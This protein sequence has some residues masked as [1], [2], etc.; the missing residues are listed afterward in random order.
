MG[1]R[2]TTLVL[3]AADDRAA[4]AWTARDTQV[5]LVTPGDLRWPGWAWRDDG[6]V[7]GVVEEHL[8]DLSEVRGVVTRLP[9][10]LPDDLTWVRDNDRTYAA[11]ECTAFLTAWL[12]SVDVPVVNRPRGGSLCG[13]INPYIVS[14]AAHQLGWRTRWTPTRAAE[15]AGPPGLFHR[16]ELVV[17]TVAGEIAHREATTAGRTITNRRV[18][19]TA[20]DPNAIPGLDETIR[21]LARAVGL[22]LLRVRLGLSTSEEGVIVEVH[23]V[24]PWIDI[25]CERV[26]AAVTDLLD[27]EPRQGQPR[28]TT[29]GTWTP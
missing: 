16:N 3:A 10:V 21:A 1:S 19:A 5:R 29:N 7:T 4:R 27:T 17:H 2:L 23:G 14:A 22:P 15:Q 13:D 9:I 6:T 24:D 25:G 20:G 8:I 12:A 11:T 18:R 28:N 26:A